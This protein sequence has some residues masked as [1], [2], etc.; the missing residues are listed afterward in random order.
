MW[1]SKVHSGSCKIRMKIKIKQNSR[2]ICFIQKN[3]KPFFWRGFYDGIK[4]PNLKQNMTKQNFLTLRQ[5]KLILVN[6]FKLKVPPEPVP[7]PQKSSMQAKLLQTKWVSCPAG[8]PPGVSG[9]NKRHHYTTWLLFCCEACLSACCENSL[10]PQPL[11]TS[12]F[13]RATYVLRKCHSAA[14]WLLWKRLRRTCLY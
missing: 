12:W 2:Q 7:F 6:P 1:M 9:G 13:Y 5:K 8:A 14:Q 4:I 3:L 11:S 10:S